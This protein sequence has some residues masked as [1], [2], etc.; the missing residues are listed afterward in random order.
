VA[1]LPA[2]GAEAASALRARLAS[3][4]E[5]ARWW[6][7]RGLAQFGDVD[8]GCFVPLL[9][10]ESAPVRECAALALCHHPH[11]EAGQQ[12]IDSLSDPDSMVATLAANALIA[13]GKEMS[14]QLVKVLQEGKPAA[15]IEAAR[16]L[17]EIRDPQTIPAL[18][19][20]LESDSAMLQYWSQ[21]A[22]ER[23]G[24]GMIYLKPE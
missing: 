8:A 17:A 2:L 14:P 22:L 19:K 13:L 9:K 7:V 12:L 3:E 24:V 4:D 11:S 16:A 18:M 15:K 1:Q 21:Q 20:I 5:D 10:D 23:L 6:A